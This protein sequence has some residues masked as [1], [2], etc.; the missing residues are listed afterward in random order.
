REV[1]GNGLGQTA[2]RQQQGAN[3]VCTR[4][5]DDHLDQHPNHNHIL[6]DRLVK[7]HRV[8]QARDDQHH[9][10]NDSIVVDHAGDDH[11]H[12][13]HAGD[14]QQHVNNNIVVVDD[15]GDDHHHVD[16]AG[17]DQQHV[18]HAGDDQHHVHDTILDDHARH[19][20]HHPPDAAPRHEHP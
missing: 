2:V 8:D 16:H 9:V 10:N 6:V 18:D 15:A 7:H 17:D 14:D 13:D 20:P 5:L 4:E 1:E 19:D 12:V 11:Y 3:H